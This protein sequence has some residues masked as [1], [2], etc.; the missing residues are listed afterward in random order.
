MAI[1]LNEKV[2]HNGV[3]FLAGDIIEKI[4]NVEAE[5]LVDLGVASF[6]REIPSLPKNEVSGSD[7]IV[8]PVHDPEADYQALDEAY[9]LEELKETAAG[10]EALNFKGTISKK[11][12]ITLIIESGKIDEFFEET[13]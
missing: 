6:V 7:Q 12:L 11:D 2:R 10:V 3:T 5:R 1:E 4:K 13:E 8:P 9:T